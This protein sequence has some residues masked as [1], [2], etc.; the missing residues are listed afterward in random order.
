M[1]DG[2]CWSTASM[3]LFVSSFRERHFSNLQ[4]G[5][6]EVAVTYV[7]TV[8]EASS[9]CR[10]NGWHSNPRR[11]LTRVPFVWTRHIFFFNFLAIGNLWTNHCS[12]VVQMI[13][14]C[15]KKSH[16][17]LSLPMVQLFHMVSR[18]LVNVLDVLCI[19]HNTFR[20]MRIFLCWNVCDIIHSGFS[21][22]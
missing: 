14:I 22:A 20:S 9:L 1:F 19:R 16:S 4:W 10:F 11:T 6:S 13:L 3:W 2:W 17:Y 12:S 15:N 5:C 21:N 7:L 18:L 8:H